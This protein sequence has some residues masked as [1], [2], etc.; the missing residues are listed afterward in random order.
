MALV[1]A[2]LLAFT[3]LDPP[4]S[5]VAVVT[6]ALVESAESFALLRWSRRRRATVGTEAL[7]GRTAVA[8]TD[9]W[10]A[11]QVKIDGELWQARCE[12]GVSAGDEVVVRGID[13]LTLEVEPA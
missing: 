1:V 13:G 8:T 3:V 12:G 7:V 9:L 5:V 2:L 10:P 6:G 4:W 11:G